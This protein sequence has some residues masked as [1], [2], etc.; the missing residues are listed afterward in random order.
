MKNKKTSMDLMIEEISEALGLSP[1]ENASDLDGEKGITFRVNLGVH[2]KYE[3]L[4]K[5]SRRKF[6]RMVR[7]MLL[8][9]I[10]RAY[11]L[12]EPEEQQKAS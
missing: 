5:D 4:Q 8:E 9:S 1:D 3:T 12:I 2:Q 7:K 10:D 11:S 6:G